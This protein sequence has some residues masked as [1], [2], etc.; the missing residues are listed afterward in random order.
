VAETLADLSDAVRHAWYADVP[1]PRHLILT[2]SQGGRTTYYTENGALT[3]NRPDG[4]KGVL[5]TQVASATFSAL[6]MPRYREAAT[7]QRGATVWSRSAPLVGL[8]QAYVLSP[9]ER[10]TIGFMLAAAA[11]VAG[12]VPAVQEQTVSASLGSFGIKASAVAPASGSVTLRLF[13]ARGPGDARPDGVA[14]GQATLAA[15]GLPAAV[16][17]PIL[18]DL[19]L[20]NTFTPTTTIGRGALAVTTTLTTL[21]LPPTVKVPI[22]L[23]GLGA[24]VQPGYAYALQLDNTSGGHVAVEGYVLASAVLS[25]V[26]LASGAGAATSQP[27]LIPAS[28]D[29]I[30]TMTRTTETAAPRNVLIELT[31]AAGDTVAG[32]VTV[33][34]QEYAPDPWLGSVP[35]EAAP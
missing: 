15:S 34:G 31:T 32:T 9:G 17:T 2:D 20:K 18:V 26:T 22:D 5:S 13:R 23:S 33:L 19:G 8:P 21:V 16:T 10:L 30:A 35:S 6:T 7:V 29:G 14:L 1:D 24:N 4:S 11:P 28:L 3:V 25:G 12:S 27:V